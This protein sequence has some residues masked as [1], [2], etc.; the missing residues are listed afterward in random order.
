MKPPVSYSRCD[1]IGVLR[2]DSA[3]VNALS[4]SVIR[5]LDEAIKA[6]EQDGEAAVMVIAC[7][8][9]TFVA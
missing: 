4:Y 7:A 6:F 9:R 5:G 1:R 8:G 2:I 3:P